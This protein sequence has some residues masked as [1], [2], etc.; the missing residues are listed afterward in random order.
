MFENIIQKTNN[1]EWQ[2][3]LGLVPGFRRFELAGKKES[4]S[5]TVFD[6]IG[7]G[8]P[9]V[10]DFPD[11]E[12]LELASAN[13]ADD[14]AGTGVQEVHIEYLDADFKEQT[15]VVETN[16]TTPVDLTSVPIH[17]SPWIHTSKPISGATKAAVGN[18]DL[19]KITGGNIINRIAA[20]GNQSLNSIFTIPANHIG[21]IRSR[22][23]SGLKQ[24][25][26]LQ[27][28]ATCERSTRILLPGV[29]LFQAAF[30][31]NDSTMS[32]NP[33][34]GLVFPPLCDTKM[35]GKGKAAGGNVTINYP[36]YLI[37]KSA[38]PK[39]SWLGLR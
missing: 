24:E 28:R 11:G 19:R 6:D 33:G 39:S 13:A 20:G 30:S 26:E 14:A 27:L 25:M 21:L 36:I 16:S 29:F 35:S 23:L 34:G 17:R 8:I 18:I 1:L 2:I 31:L 3:S 22:D 10:Y 12:P 4:I 9:S 32:S 37:E 5:T 15:L 7:E 38:I